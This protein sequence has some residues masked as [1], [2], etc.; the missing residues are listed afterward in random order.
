[1]IRNVFHAAEEQHEC[2]RGDLMNDDPFLAPKLVGNQRVEKHFYY[3]EAFLTLRIYIP[4]LTSRS[5]LPTVY[6]CSIPLRFKNIKSVLHVAE[7]W[8]NH[9]TR[10]KNQQITP[11]GSRERHP[12]RE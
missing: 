10:R 4:V 1:M 7:L 9:L 12:Y 5:A 8:V 6:S 11:Q 2:M 3:Y